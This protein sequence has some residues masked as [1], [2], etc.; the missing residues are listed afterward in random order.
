[1]NDFIQPP[2]DAA[3]PPPSATAILITRARDGDVDARE[4][5]FARFLPV[6][7]EWAHRRLPVN[8]RDL[9]E[10]ADLVQ[11]TLL[12][13]LNHLERFESRG[14]GAFLAYLRAIL[15]NVIRQEIRRSNRRGVQESL[16][17]TLVSPYASVVERSIGIE[18]LERYQR[19]LDSLS[20][21]RQHAV[22]LRIE[23]GYSYAQIAEALDKPSADAARMTVVR[24]LEQLVSTIDRDGKGPALR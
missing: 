3:N 17:E 16:H 22:L 11:I 15:L 7:R 6:L 24:A 9:N 20:E 13:A 18:Q 14:E 21:D 19:A 12:R 23:F 4:E 8:A 1:M 10:T 5:L 2:G